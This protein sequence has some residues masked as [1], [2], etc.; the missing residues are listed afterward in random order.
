MVYSITW[1]TYL[2]SL[3]SLS[4]SGF[5]ILKLSFQKKW[6]YFCLMPQMIYIYIYCSV[7][8]WD[9]WM[10]KELKVGVFSLP[11]WAPWIGSAS[12][13]DLTVACGKCFVASHSSCMMSSAILS[14]A[15]LP[16]SFPWWRKA[17]H[18]I[19]L[20]FRVFVTAA[21]IISYYLIFILTSWFSMIHPIQPSLFRKKAMTLFF[22][23]AEISCGD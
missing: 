18:L 6:K 11:L 22:A 9:K 20:R 15:A 19:W 13:S 7:F 14:R 10:P 1:Y 8:T 16:A 21:Q 23:G 2:K 4:S 3:F 12:C 5:K 17:L